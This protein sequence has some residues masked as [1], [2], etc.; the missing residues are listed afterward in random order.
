PAAADD[1]ANSLA[2]T[3]HPFG[4]VAINGSSSG[5]LETAGDR[6][7]FRVQLAAGTTY[8]LSLQAL[9]GG[10]G[11]LVDP[12]LRLH[13][14]SGAL[15]AQNDDIIDGVNRDSQLSYTARTSGT[16]YLEAGAFQDS[17]AGTYQI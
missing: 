12:Y 7:W 6:D 15:L 11:T 3:S 2:D 14:A 1:F 5:N 10:G 16:Y 13:D 17:Y 8:L 9:H 4:Q